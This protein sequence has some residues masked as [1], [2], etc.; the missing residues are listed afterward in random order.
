[1][2]TILLTNNYSSIPLS[3]I[4][5]VVPI[6]FNLIK[7]ETLSEEELIK[8]IPLADYLL[9]SG[10]LSINKRILDFANKLKM[11]QRTGVGTD[12]L[13]KEAIKRKEIPLYVNKGINANGVA[14]HT[15]LLIL[16]SLRKTTLINLNVKKGI[17]NK[18]ATGL[19]THELKGK[20]VGLVGMGSV[21]Q[22]VAELLLP[23]KVNLLYSDVQRLPKEKEE[24][25]NIR[26]TQF[27]YLIEKSDIIT[28]HCA[29]TTQTRNI[30]GE[31]EIHQMKDDVI[32]INTARGKLIDELALIEGLK[33]G[34]VSFAGLDV[35]SNE[36]IGENSP[37]Y[38][39][40]NVILTPHI[41]GVT[42]E[43]FHDM[44]KEAM[45]NIV[46]FENKQFEDIQNKRLL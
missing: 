13:D 31:K 24:K 19:S 44:M 3:I 26:Y 10:R 40:E 28:L 6:G 27:Q 21:G 45:H 38:Q 43:A 39:L 46:L 33:S 12:M 20:T 34:K 41:G 16:S 1:M 7:L 4:Y 35:F 29:L 37:L 42:N 8:K 36:P 17:W 22:R 15:L 23:F 2:P 5:N 25:L 18:Q 9:V 14:E 32:I 30:I 11:I